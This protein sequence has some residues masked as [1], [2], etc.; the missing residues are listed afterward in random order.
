[1]PR[2]TL[3]RARSTARRMVIYGPPGAGKT[4]LAASVPGAAVL[5]VEDGLADLDVLSFPQPASWGDAR[6]VVDAV[7]AGEYPEVRALV[8][9]SVTRLEALAHTHLV[10]P[11]GGTVERWEGGYNKWRQGALDLCWR[12][13]LVALDRVVARGIDVILVAHSVVRTARDPDSDGWDQYQIQLE[14]L[15]ASALIQWADMVLCLVPEIVT[16]KD[17]VTATGARVLRTQASA[18]CVAKTRL[19][20]PPVIVVP[21]EYPWGALAP[22][23]SVPEELRASTAALVARLPADLRAR[24][25]E[26]LAR[27]TT[28]G[29]VTA[30]AARAQALLDGASA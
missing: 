13:L 8:I 26:A 10:G 14:A 24:A 30:I 11:T 20:L 18:P 27:A 23:L 9:D 12:P 7:A 3:A 22:Y 19:P 6:A 5:P 1:M 2:P 21:P 28:A 29:A 15:A 16:R 4:T 17:S 25:E